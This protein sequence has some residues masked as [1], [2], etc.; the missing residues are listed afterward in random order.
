MKYSARFTCL[1][2]CSGEWRVTEAIYSC[3]KCGGLLQ[4]EQRTDGKVQAFRIQRAEPFVD[5]QRI[6]L[7]AAGARLH[8]VGQ[9]QRE[10]QRR[11]EPLAA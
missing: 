8:H 2:G 4:V 9:A 3:P 5:E 10:R 6:E 11:Q 1:S 7:D